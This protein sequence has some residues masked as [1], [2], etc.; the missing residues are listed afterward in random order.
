VFEELLLL[1]H[2]LLLLRVL[3]LKELLRLSHHIGWNVLLGMLLLWVVVRLLLQ[4]LLEGSFWKLWDRCGWLLRVAPSKTVM[5]AV[6]I[7]TRI[8]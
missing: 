6:G 4:L 8:C 2:R 3:L 5:V 1:I 7:V